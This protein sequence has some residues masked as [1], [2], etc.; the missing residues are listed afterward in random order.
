MPD[1]D[2]I[3][4]NKITKPDRQNIQNFF[5]ADRKF[6]VHTTGLD[7]YSVENAQLIEAILPLEE[8]EKLLN[9][10]TQL[11][12]NGIV[13]EVVQEEEKVSDAVKTTTTRKRKA[14][15]KCQ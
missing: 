14:R 12:Y 3:L 8:R 1:D 10:E 4:G 7:N 9:G 6:K 2:L 15:A 11:T 5:S 13:I